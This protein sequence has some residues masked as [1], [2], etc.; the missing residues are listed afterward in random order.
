M[1]IEGIWIGNCLY[2]TLIHTARKYKYYE[3]NSLTGLHTLDSTVTAAHIK[4]CTSP[5]VVYC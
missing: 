4:S 3:D 1:G 5:L 2:S